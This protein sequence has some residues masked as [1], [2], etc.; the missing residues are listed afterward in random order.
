MGQ[1]IRCTVN[2]Q[3]NCVDSGCNTELMQCATQQEQEKASGVALRVAHSGH[4]EYILNVS[5]MRDASELMAF[6]D[7]PVS[8][9]HD[10]DRIIRIAAM[11]ELTAR[12]RTAQSCQAA[13]SSAPVASQSDRSSAAIHSAHPPELSSPCSTTQGVSSHMAPVFNLNTRPQV[14][15]N[16]LSRRTLLAS[17]TSRSSSSAYALSNPLPGPS[18]PIR[19]PDQS[20][21]VTASPHQ[22]TPLHLNAAAPPFPHPHVSNTLRPGQANHFQPSCVPPGL[23]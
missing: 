23:F 6:R 19:Q 12:R 14:S 2:V 21:S 11:Q 4:T 1:D 10:R 8:L 9:Q 17:Y 7:R 20:I 15:D 16:S 3:H 18:D 22:S 13:A 5:Q